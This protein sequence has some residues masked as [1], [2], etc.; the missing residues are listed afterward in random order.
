MSCKPIDFFRGNMRNINGNAKT[1]FSLALTLGL[2]VAAATA[3]ATR[4]EATEMDCSKPQRDIAWAEKCRLQDRNNPGS[5][6]TVH[7]TNNNNPAAISGSRSSSNS[8]ATAGALNLN[9]IDQR[10]LTNQVLNNQI[11]LS[12]QQRQQLLNQNNISPELKAALESTQN[13]S[14][15][16]NPENT[17]ANSANNE[18]INI[19]GDDFT[20]LYFNPATAYATP[21]GNGYYSIR[22]IFGEFFQC[23]TPAESV[24]FSIYVAAASW[25]NQSDQASAFCQQAIGQVQDMNRVAAI[26]HFMPALPLVQQQ[27]VARETITW[28]G[29]SLGINF[30]FNQS[31]QTTLI[32]QET[33]I[34]VPA[35]PPQTQTEV[36]EPN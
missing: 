24:S 23:P 3:L 33:I 14:I 20:S 22:G 7:N 30:D 12:P 34:F 2:S 1:I 29:S 6:T 13:T 32:Q 18:G 36:D 17:N 27:Y 10:Q 9:D 15:E 4:A 35:N 19:G 5:P 26:S 21:I 11:Q 31:Q 8:N 25:A 16:N 28:L